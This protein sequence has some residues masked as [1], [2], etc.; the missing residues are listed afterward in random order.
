MIDVGEAPT[1]IPASTLKVFTCLLADQ[2]LG[3]ES[4][5][6]TRFFLDGDPLI[7]QGG[8]DPFLVSEELDAIVAALDGPLGATVLSGVFRDDSPFEPGIVLPALG[9]SGTPSRA[10]RL[11]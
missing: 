3:M 11:A 4:R 9:G 6:E 5:F 8:G 10:S 7:V 1:F 2:H